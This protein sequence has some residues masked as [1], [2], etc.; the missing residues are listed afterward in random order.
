[1]RWLP[2]F[3]R[4]DCATPAEDKSMEALQDSQLVLETAQL[5]WQRVD[6]AADRAAKAN[7]KVRSQRE[8]NHLAEIV[9]T[10]LHGG[11]HP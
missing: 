6:A 10:A 7:A 4:D 3:H 2:F 1:M 9:Y 11:K 5:R 8:Q